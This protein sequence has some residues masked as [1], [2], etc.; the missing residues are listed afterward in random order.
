M[1]EHRPFRCMQRP[2]LRLVAVNGVRL[3]EPRPYARLADCDGDLWADYQC[4]K[5][6]WDHARGTDDPNREHY[7]GAA[8]AAHNAWAKAHGVALIQQP[9]RWGFN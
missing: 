8:I 9:E 6:D 1:M 4:A 7:R 2:N 3:E 5:A